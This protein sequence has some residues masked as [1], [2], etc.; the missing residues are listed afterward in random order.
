MNEELIKAARAVLNAARA[1]RVS[2]NASLHP[3]DETGLALGA[4]VDALEALLAAEVAPIEE[5]VPWSRVVSGDSVQ[6][7]SGEWVPVLQRWT[8][9]KGV[10]VTVELPLV[11]PADPDAT[12]RRKTYLMQPTREVTRRQ[13]NVDEAKAIKLLIE[14]LGARVIVSM[15]EAW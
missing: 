8:R 12:P 14:Q 9:R 4:A 6:L 15:E 10:E 7:K 1:W 5:R 3:E 13:G 11:D 2:H